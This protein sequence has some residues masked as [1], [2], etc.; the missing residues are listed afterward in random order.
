MVRVVYM[1]RDLRGQYYKNHSSGSIRW[2]D[3][4]HAQIFPQ[5]SGAT[6]QANRCNKSH[7][8]HVIELE[9]MEP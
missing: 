1:V 7:L 2:V 9:L 5:K 8:A 4:E 6:A 3:F